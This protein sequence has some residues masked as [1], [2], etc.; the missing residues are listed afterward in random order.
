MVGKDGGTDEALED[1]KG[2]ETEVAAKDGEV[3]LEER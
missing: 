1:T 3:T 2:A